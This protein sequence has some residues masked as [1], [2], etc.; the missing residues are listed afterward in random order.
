MDW[1]VVKKIEYLF[2]QCGY[3]VLMWPREKGNK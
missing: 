3:P 1:S 2:K